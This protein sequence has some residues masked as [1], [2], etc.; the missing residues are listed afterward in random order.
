MTLRPAARDYAPQF[1]ASISLSFNRTPKKPPQSFPVGYIFSA[2]LLIFSLLQ[3]RLAALARLSFTGRSVTSNLLCF[4]FGGEAA[5]EQSALKSPSARQH[6]SH[7]ATFCERRK[8][9]Y[10]ESLFSLG[11]ML[12]QARKMALYGEEGGLVSVPGR[13]TFSLCECE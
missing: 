6:L 13:A 11:N 10:F 5:V 4:V 1:V 3:T 2:G 9:R 7:F 8:K 12:G